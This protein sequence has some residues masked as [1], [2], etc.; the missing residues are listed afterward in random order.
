MNSILSHYGFGEYETEFQLFQQYFLEWNN[1]INL[2]SRKD[3]EAFMTHHV[4]HSLSILKFFGFKNGSKLLDLGTGGGFPGI[5]LA[6][7]LPDVEFT[8]IDSTGK[9]IA[10]VQDMI[11]QLGLKNATAMHKRAEEMKGQYDFVVTRA[12]AEFSKLLPWSRHLISDKHQNSYPNGLIA[13]K[14]ETYIDELKRLPQKVYHEAN[15]I[16]DVFPEPYFDRK[17]VIYIQK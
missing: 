9:K 2:I 11:E 8:L 16:H 7:C 5:P 10:A 12:V 14:G 13:L 3:T 15:S 17:F 1:K 4:L 6:I